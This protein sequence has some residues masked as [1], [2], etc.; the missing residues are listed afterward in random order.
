M[1]TISETLLSEWLQQ[2]DLH[3]E[4]DTAAFRN[5]VKAVRPQPFSQ[6]QPTAFAL[7]QLQDILSNNESLRIAFTSKLVSFIGQA[8]Q[9]EVFT[10]V[11]ALSRTGFI[12]DLRRLLFYKV[13]APIENHQELGT[14][15][16]KVFNNKNDVDWI[17]AIPADDLALFF[18]QIGIIPPGQLPSTHY[19][20][21][22]L[23]DDL[24]LLTQ[25]ITSLSM[26]ADIIRNFPEL[27]SR[28]SPYNQLH[29]RVSE[30]IQQIGLSQNH[31]QQ[32]GSHY[33]AIQS[34]WK[35]CVDYTNRIHD[36]KE[37]YGTS[38]HLTITLQKLNKCLKRSNHI[39]HLIIKHDQESD[40][41]F[42]L[43]AFV[44]AVI[45]SEIRKYSVRNLINESVHTLTYQITEHTGKTG[46][47]YITSSRREY[48][49]MFFSAMKGGLVISFMVVI[50]YLIGLLRLP[51][52]QDT[53]LK[54]L[55]YSFGF[56]GIH[57][58]HG[59]VATKQPAMTASAVAQSIALKS[60]QEEV[61]DIG[62]VILKVFRSQFAAVAGNLM[63]VFPMAFIIG[64]VYYSLNGSVLLPVAEAHHKY[65]M[66]HPFKSLALVHAA[67]AGVMLF[68]SGILSG[69]ADNANLYN[70]Y[71]DRIKK[72]RFLKK[73]I[74]T[75]WSYKLGN[76]INHQLGN[77]TGNFSLGFLLAVVAFFGYITGLPLDI[78]HVAFATGNLGFAAASIY[79][80]ITWHEAIWAG[81]GVMAIGITNIGVSFSLT[82]IVVVK[83]RGISLTLMPRVLKYVLL[84]FAKNPF[85]FF[86]PFYSKQ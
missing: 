1:K 22:E 66:L 68:L 64:Y 11:T 82:L 74:G 42:H 65:E 51:V 16:R 39:I 69:L 77:L 43:A 84:E 35:D 18:K 13:L 14:I 23:L 47:H 27:L 26:D 54:G 72:A 36:S 44:K 33:N 45:T 71:A 10:H 38:L 20:I 55:N 86:L 78:Q 85:R 62:E 19:I 80:H 7:I 31:R 12:R 30:W 61:K 75:K 4:T 6:N 73:T 17:N 32:S 60:Q 76:Y 52:L 83:S 49:N 53:F 28:T 25:M 59:V 5:I 58:W 40:D 50:K 9:T 79:D 34:A 21:Q 29:E 67:I 63:M 24:L 46:E 48:N 57:L 8:R 3:N 70:R 41:F 15:V 37:Q 2:T 81:V 56:I